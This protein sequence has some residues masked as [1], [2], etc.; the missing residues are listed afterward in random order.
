MMNKI[1]QVSFNDNKRARSIDPKLDLSILIQFFIIILFV[2]SV[3]I[4][5]VQGIPEYSKIL[6]QDLKNFCNICHESN[7]GGPLNS[8]GEDYIVYQSDLTGLMVLD[9]DADGYPNGEELNSGMSP[10]NPE[11][12]PGAKKESYILEIFVLF[13]IILSVSFTA[14]KFIQI[15]Q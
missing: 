11:S 1:C 7:S 10:G 12:Y 14:F 6:P 4:R 9:S 13:L 2:S 8:F 5:S 3:S 15:Q